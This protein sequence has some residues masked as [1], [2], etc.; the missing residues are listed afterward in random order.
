[1]IVMGF[2]KNIL[3]GYTMGYSLRGVG[4]GS[5]TLQ[6]SIRNVTYAINLFVVT[7]IQLFL[8][9]FQL[10]LKLRSECRLR[11]RHGDL[12]VSICLFIC[13]SLSS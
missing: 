7:H 13:L 12:N 10:V 5:K 8:C 3:M 9:I 11:D 2:K 6:E 4:G 1:M